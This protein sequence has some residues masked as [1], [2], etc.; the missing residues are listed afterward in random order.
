MRKEIIALVSC[1]KGKRD[2]P[3]TAKDLY[4]SGLFRKSRDYAEQNA[5]RW[6]VLSAKYGLVSPEKFIEPYEQTLKGTRVR[7][8]RE[9]AARVHAQMQQQGLLHDGVSFL[10]LAGQNYQRELRKLLS[11]FPQ[12]D[13]LAGKRIG[14]RKAWLKA[15]IQNAQLP[16]LGGT[17][18]TKTSR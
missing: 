4:T 18:A 14:P 9:W 10:W 6:F 11:P 8:R 3:C 12:N 16:R 5:D 15:N 2:S 1:V 7:E 13:P 17:R